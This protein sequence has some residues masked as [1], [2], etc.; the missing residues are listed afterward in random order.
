MRPALF[1]QLDNRFATNGRDVSFQVA[2]AGF[3]GIVVD[4]F[5]DGVLNEGYLVFLQTVCSQLTR[6]EMPLSNAQFLHIRVAIQLDDLHAVAQRTRY[7]VQLI[8]RRDED[9]LAQVEIHI[10]VMVPESAVLCRIQ[11]F[12]QCAGGITAPVLSDLVDL[13]EHE[14]RITC[15][16][17]F[18]GLDDS[19]GHGADIG[20]PMAADFGFVPHATQAHAG[21]LPPQGSGHAAAQAGFA[22]TRGTG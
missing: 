4:D 18:D 5:K 7:G 21:E 22:D 2:Y 13:V 17:A 9:H 8:G 11:H 10:Q 14:D 1:T 19:S 16:G 12:Q 6:N 20:A 15:T 3:A